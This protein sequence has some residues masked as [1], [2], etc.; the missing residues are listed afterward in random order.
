MNKRIVTSLRTRLLLSYL[1]VVAIGVIGMV[2]GVRLVAPTLFDRMMVSMGGSG[3]M[4][5]R[6]AN[7]MDAVTRQAF[8]SAVFDA[9]LIATVFS[10]LAAVVVSVFVAGRITAPLRRMVA[11]SR[12]MAGGDFQVRVPLADHDEIGML[13]ASLNDM[14][15]R[16]QEAESRRVHLVGDVAHELR[17]PLATL[18]GYLEGLEDGVVAP[19][20]E[21]WTELHGEVTRLT[22]LVDDL[23]ELS[24]VEAGAVSLSKRA[25]RAEEIILG[26]V[27]PLRP[28][29]EQKHVELRMA[30]SPSLPAVSADPDRIIQVLTNLLS[31]A[32]RYTPPGGQVT[33][34]VAAID[35]QVAFRVSDTGAGIAPE[36][37]PHIFDRF[38]R[39]DPSRSRTAGG[40][41]IGLTIARALVEA[42]GGRIQAT[43]EGAGRGAVFTFTLPKA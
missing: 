10:T 4:S 30:P 1:L 22:R 12:Q 17:T 3:M 8:T 36:H 16:L 26:A 25:V 5:G 42:H 28:A 41:G 7:G 38:Y 35:D 2:L 27:T 6:S 34:S 15:T 9:L 23:Q 14:G 11:A 40:A 19:T 21:L 37:L 39:A 31:N 20:P 32:V 33:I 13:A 43:S 18:R 29:F 24:R